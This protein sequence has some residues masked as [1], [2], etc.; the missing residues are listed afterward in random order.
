MVVSA[1]VVNKQN[2]LFSN[3]APQGETLKKTEFVTVGEKK[4]TNLTAVKKK[5][6]K[7]K[8]GEEERKGSK[9]KGM[10]GR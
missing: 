7:Q 8:I 4:Q 6:E 1:Y 10:I 5:E 3:T 2:T 9:N